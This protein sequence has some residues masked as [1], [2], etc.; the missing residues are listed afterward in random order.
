MY[1]GVHISLISVREQQI[2][3]AY[4]TLI[5]KIRNRNLKNVCTKISLKKSENKK[6]VF[7]STMTVQ[8]AQL[9]KLVI[10]SLIEER[11]SSIA[12][13]KICLFCYD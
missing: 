12:L 1:F 10:T 9:P 8:L 13:K 11:F 7:F 6:K 3:H 2:P 5:F 4:N